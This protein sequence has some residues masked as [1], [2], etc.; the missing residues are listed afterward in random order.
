MNDGI[1]KKEYESFDFP[2]FEVQIDKD[3][4]VL[5]VH[6][7]SNGCTAVRVHGLN[8]MREFVHGKAHQVDIGFDKKHMYVNESEN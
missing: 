7:R 2:G 3:R 6:D 8:S 1:P 5:Y 4:G